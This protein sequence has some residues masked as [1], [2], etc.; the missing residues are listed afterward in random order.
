MIDDY[1]IETF[2]EHYDFIQENGVKMTF[3]VTRY[4]TLSDKRKQMFRQIYTDGH[5][6]G[7]HGTH[8]ISAIEYLKD[9]TIEE[10]INYEILP[11]LEMMKHDG[12]N[13]TNF[14]YPY[15]KHT[16]ELDSI[17]LSRFF[18]SLKLGTTRLILYN[19]PIAKGIVRP[20]PIDDNYNIRFEKLL[21]YADTAKKY[22]KIIM[23]YAHKL[24]PDNYKI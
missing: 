18:Y 20:I 3:M 11:D 2:M 13:V 22:N 17:L 24:N 15:G 6:L 16:P 10:Y 9:H 21:A 8:H 1:Y 23:F 7:F 14:S 19:V 4:H 5:E 12:Y